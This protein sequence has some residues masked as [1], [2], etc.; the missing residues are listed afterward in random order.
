ML[1]W[2]SGRN[3]V[4]RGQ[5][6]R[7]KGGL[8]LGIVVKVFGL[9]FAAPKKRGQ[10]KGAIAAGLFAKRAG[11]FWEMPWRFREIPCPFRLKGEIR[12]GN[13]LCP[14]AKRGK[15]GM[16]SRYFVHFSSRPRRKT[17][18]K[19]GGSGRGKNSPPLRRL[20]QLPPRLLGSSP[21]PFG[22][23]PWPFCEKGE[24]RDGNPAGLFI[25]LRGRRPPVA[26]I[27]YL[28]FAAPKKRHQKKGAVSPLAG[29]KGTGY[30]QA[31][32]P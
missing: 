20:K 18:Q 9:F 31:D 23:Y 13:T 27:L 24:T 15:R 16:E 29:N 2:K 26:A 11:A 25:F 19:E 30:C 32:E 4:F 5:S 12:E 10:K 7:W 14:F 17:N 3:V 22:K 1:I 6:G 21:L 8:G 28:F